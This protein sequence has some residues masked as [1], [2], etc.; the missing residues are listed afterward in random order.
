MRGKDKT[1]TKCTKANA[2]SKRWQPYGHPCKE[3]EG[4]E[5]VHPFLKGAAAGPIPGV[6][7]DKPKHSGAA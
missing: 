3:G 6:V 7:E 4:I 1:H 2:V 5:P